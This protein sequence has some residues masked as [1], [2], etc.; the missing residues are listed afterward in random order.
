MKIHV[1]ICERGEVEE[2][3]D[4]NEGGLGYRGGYDPRIKYDRITG[5]PVKH[6]PDDRR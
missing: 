1:Y 2:R 3:S 6:D 4:R 5:E